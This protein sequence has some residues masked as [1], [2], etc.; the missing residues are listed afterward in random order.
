MQKAITHFPL[1]SYCLHK[2]LLHI[3]LVFGLT[4]SALNA[5]AQEQASRMPG[6]EQ[7][8]EAQTSDSGRV[9]IL[10]ELACAAI[11]EGKKEKAF[12]QA[13]LVQ[14]LA[15]KTGDKRDQ[16][17]AVNALGYILM[18]TG[19]IDGG[20]AKFQQ[21]LA[22]ARQGSSEALMMNAASKIG[23]A[24]LLKGDAETAVAWQKTALAH[25]NRAKMHDSIQLKVTVYGDIY[26][27]LNA[28]GKDVF[29]A[30]YLEDMVRLGRKTGVYFTEAWASAALSVVY[31]K[32]GDYS[33]S[34]F[35]GNN[36]LT[37][38]QNNK[39][40][41]VESDANM[42]LAASYNAMGDPAKAVAYFLKVL[43]YY[44]AVG[45]VHGVTQVQN[46]MAEVYFTNKDY[47]KALELYIT[48]LG[49]AK[50]NKET[51]IEAASLHNIGEIYHEQHNDDMAMQN[52]RNALTINNA[53]RNYQF[54]V[55]NNLGM[56]T[57]HLTARN[58]DSALYHFNLA[59]RIAADVKM[60]D[61]E[62]AAAS[63]IGKLWLVKATDSS[64]MP[65]QHE[66]KLML[67]NAETQLTIAATK[68][69]EI[70]LLNKLEEAYHDLSDV[71]KESGDYR[72]AMEYY[73]R[74]ILLKDSLFSR[75]N[76]FKIARLE[77]EAAIAQKNRELIHTKDEASKLKQQRQYL[78][79]G[80]GAL[81]LLAA[82]GFVMY[83]LRQHRK[84][85]LIKTE[86]EKQVAEMEMQALRAQMNPHFIFNCLNSINRYIVK[87]DS[88]TASGYLTKFSKLIRL[89]L[90]HS[91][92][93]LISLASEKQT[94]LLYMEM[95]SLRF[96]GRFSYE[97]TIDPALDPDTILIPA[98]LIQ[99]YI[100]NAIWHGLMHKESGGKV[101]VRFGY[102][103]A[104]MLQVVVEDDGIGR[105][106]A[107]LLKSRNALKHK[108]H[109]MRITG[110]RLRIVS[111]QQG[112]EAS[113]RIDD[114]KDSQ[115][116]ACGTRISLVIPYERVLV[117]SV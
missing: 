113:L 21:A 18:K 99:P 33:R 90:D 1:F 4:A 30:P 13:T 37:L 9:T 102:H 59:N 95:E 109:G 101:S 46:N 19:D 44:K 26:E 81:V 5:R 12:R 72:A 2:M 60:P 103:D 28:A 50:Q 89:I 7:Q 88:V 67:N 42:H 22:L 93:G 83:R 106:Q 16:S 78:Y 71:Y 114:L 112:T 49:I 6:L 48:N 97:V 31:F 41:L 8:L 40:P 92:S 47:N 51:N 39:N 98:M 35:Y 54:L 23:K 105:E 11:E 17:I 24:M 25:L 56:G 82:V 32:T 117:E 53:N 36:E 69:K 66:R 116:N 70:G 43:E 10:A 68:F 29:A 73:Q 14:D 100:E 64:H 65:T 79:A 55:Q 63:S 77:N 107:A 61:G 3:A 52:Y 38:A 45:N 76:T 84:A 86:F 74:S 62:A 34:I 91:A 15:K 27:A 115:G 110:D 94:L 58:Y 57:V 80:I 20:I 75:Q 104:A 96:S 87:S 85:A 111:E 108:S